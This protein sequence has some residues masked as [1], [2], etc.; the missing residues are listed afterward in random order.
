M[1][2]IQLLCDIGEL[3]HLFR[4]SISVEN[5]MQRT[6][7][8]VASHM[9]VNVCSIY[10]YDDDEEQL[11]LKATVGL[12]PQA[13]GKVAL[14]LGQGLTGKALKELR[15]L[16]VSNANEDP[17]NEHFNDIDE[18]KY[19]NFLAVPITRG[20]QRIGVLVLQRHKN[21]FE[22][23]DIMACRAVASQLANIIENAKFLMT[24]HVSH[25]PKQ[26]SEIPEELRFIRGKSASFGFAHAKARVIDK[27]RS[28]A[29]LMEK[30]FE[31]GYTMED[32]EAALDMTRKQLENL[33]SQIEEKLSDAASLIFASHLMI[34]KDHEFIG[35]MRKLI[36][37][38]ENPPEA[39]LKIAS[40]YISIFT[41]SKND[42][43]REKVQD[44]EDLTVRLVGNL[45]QEKETLGQYSN[46]ILIVRNLFPSD[47][48]R[49]SSEE[50]VGIILVGGAVTS[51]LAIL[52]RSL[53]IPMVVTNKSALMNIRKNIDVLIDGETGNIYLEPAQDVVSSISQRIHEHQQLR[54]KQFIAKPTTLTSDG[55]RI[56]LRAN[57]NLLSDLGVASELG[58]EGIGLYRTE[59]PFIIRN[60][61]PSETEQLVPYRRLVKAMQGKPVVFRTLD[62]GGDKVLSYYENP[63][64]QNPSLGMRSIRFSLQNNDVFTSQIRAMLRASEGADV[65]IMFPMISSL[66]EF[67]TA[68]QIVYECIS[69][70]ENENLSHNSNPKIGMMVELPSVVNLI[71][72][73]AAEADFFSIGTNDF[74]QFMLGVDRTNQNVENFYIPHHPAV[75][76]SIAHVVKSVNRSGKEISIC[77]DM[78]RQT[79]YLEFLIG[80]GVR[81]LSIDPS[82]VP[83][84]QNAVEKIDVKRARKLAKKVL[85]LTTSDSI[86]EVLDIQNQF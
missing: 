31:T 24:M 41:S 53:K 28:F 70:L 9:K 71:D 33:Q 18:E 39:V 73:F 77:G 14:Q 40:E 75:L 84:V 85:T 62:I 12:K 26:E 3:N 42:Y 64:E 83:D 19:E 52:A 17:S 59:F 7:E 5:F 15:P 58:L 8:M 63:T 65:R 47:L 2:H 34:L 72:A 25:E 86:A 55:T 43:V 66:E 56:I 68:K 51:H 69:Q 78:A 74:I 27:Q 80:V 23:Q 37:Q 20:L 48:L 76:R 44:I 38:G 4:E 1:E 50:A 21:P 82:A 36:E 16:C 46:Q 45:M 61:F 60:D 22:K 32:F 10:I 11:M 57:I 13:I 6:V 67:T 81:I 30:H 79:H 49:I 54:E 35:T 29:N